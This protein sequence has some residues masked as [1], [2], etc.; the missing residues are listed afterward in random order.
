MKGLEWCLT[1]GWGGGG[2]CQQALDLVAGAPQEHICRVK[3]KATAFPAGTAA[4]LPS[5]S[6]VGKSEEGGLV[7]AGPSPPVC[8]AENL[9]LHCPC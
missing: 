7:E 2:F 5:F 6:I 8:M 9:T 1:L 3:D 4:L